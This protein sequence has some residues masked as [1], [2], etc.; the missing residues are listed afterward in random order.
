M[1]A[2]RFKATSLRYAVGLTLG[3]VASQVLWNGWS[4][5]GMEDVPAPELPGEEWVRIRTRYG[6]ICGSD[7]S[8][9]HLRV[10]PYYAPFSSSPFTIGHENVGHIETVGRVVDDWKV[11]ERVVVE[12]VLWCRPRGFEELCAFC[13]RGE[14]NRCERLGEGVLAPGPQI[15]N[16]RDTGGSWSPYFVAHRSQLYRIPDEVSDE[17]ALMLEPFTI[18]VHA[19]LQGFPADDERVLIL[20]AGTVGLNVLAALRALGSQATIQVLARYPFQAEAARNLGASEVITPPRGTQ[21]LEEIARR[22]GSR[23]L[24]PGMGRGMV[25]SWRLREYA[26]AGRLPRPLFEDRFLQGRVDRTFEC[27]GSDAALDD[28]LY[29]TR[30]GGTVILAGEPG[31]TRGVNWTTA[32]AKELQLIPAYLY[33]H[34]E[35][36][37]GA[38]WKTFDL[39]LDLMARGVVDLSWMVTH[40]FALEDYQTAFAMHKR[41]APHALIKGVF[42]FGGG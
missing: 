26:R 25:I 12:P 31:V 39:A 28:A 19:A 21:A 20:G 32:W 40:R 24:K 9:I 11:G 17:N 3:G 5:T 16:C 15:G 33:N 4:C 34:C 42:D 35:S 18:G 30:A 41:R 7:L 1:K 22:T 2:I 23:L 8:V 6:G 27:V 13:A 38:R 36:W 29:L 14:I 37:G 10:G